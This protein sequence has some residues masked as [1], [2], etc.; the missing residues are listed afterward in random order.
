MKARLV[1]AI[2]RHNTRRASRDGRLRRSISSE[3]SPIQIAVRSLNISSGR[4]PISGM[5]IGDRS[6]RNT[7]SEHS[8]IQVGIRVAARS[9]NIGSMGLR[10]IALRQMTGRNFSVRRKALMRRRQECAGR[11]PRRKATF[12]R[13][14][15]RVL[16]GPLN[17]SMRRRDIWDRG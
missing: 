7:S 13:M 2:R 12:R 3:R 4:S 17:S 16:R 9:R 10:R 14:D 8:R 15:G 11:Q 5:R 6:S 1:R